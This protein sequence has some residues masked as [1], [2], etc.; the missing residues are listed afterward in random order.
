MGL[1]LFELA[2]V[3]ILYE[4]MVYKLFETKANVATV[5]EWA[6]VACIQV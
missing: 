2:L 5:E 3:Q 1:H 4:A 6:T